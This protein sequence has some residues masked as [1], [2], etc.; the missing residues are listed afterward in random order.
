MLRLLCLL[1]VIIAFGVYSVSVPKLGMVIL[2]GTVFANKKQ[3]VF[4]TD[5]AKLGTAAYEA[6]NK[7]LCENV[8]YKMRRVQDVPSF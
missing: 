1:G 6:M 7:S 2:E 4:S 8:S 5:Q 3:A